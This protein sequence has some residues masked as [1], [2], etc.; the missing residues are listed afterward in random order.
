MKEYGIDKCKELIKEINISKYNQQE[1]AEIVEDIFY[2]SSTEKRIDT[3]LWKLKSSE[4]EI[5]GYK[6]RLKYSEDLLE[7]IARG[8][9]NE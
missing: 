3:L 9:L 7:K 1:Y 4:M 5:Q 6:S 8:R 2:A